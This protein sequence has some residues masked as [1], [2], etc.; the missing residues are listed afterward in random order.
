VVGSVVGSVFNGQGSEYKKSRNR[1]LPTGIEQVV[2]GFE[3]G[4]IDF[5][6]DGT[7]PALFFKSRSKGMAIW[8]VIACNSRNP[9][10]PLSSHRLHVLLRVGRDGFDPTYL[11]IQE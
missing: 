8:P 5:A 11:W 3:N 7:S 6:T 4:S 2:R 10:L 1:V 9:L